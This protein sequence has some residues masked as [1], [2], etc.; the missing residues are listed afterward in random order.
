MKAGLRLRCEDD[1][2]DNDDDDDDDKYSEW[3]TMISF[4]WFG[5]YIHMYFWNWSERLDSD[6]AKAIDSESEQIIQSLRKYCYSSNFFNF[7]DFS[8]DSEIYSTR[9]K[10]GRGL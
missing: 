7:R 10:V 8:F 4:D 3:Q 2:D 9:C 1:D 5:L 6:S